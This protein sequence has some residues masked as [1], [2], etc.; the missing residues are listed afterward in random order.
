M[1]ELPEVVTVSRALK[2]KIDHLF[3][4]DIEIYYDKI[5]DNVTPSEFKEKLIGQQFLRFSTLGKYLIFELSDYT[6][7]VHLRMEGKFYYYNEEKKDKHIHLKFVLSNND[8]LYYHD[9]RKFG[10]MYVYDKS[11]QYTCLNGLGL[12]LFNPLM[13]VKYLKSHI[14]DKMVLKQFLLDQHII[15]GIGNIYA[16]EICFALQLHPETLMNTLS[17]SQLQALIDE[18]III[19]NEAIRCGGTTIRSYT[20]SYEIS[21]RFQLSLKAHARE[22]ENCY[23][24]GTPIKKI[25]VVGRGTY[26]CCSCQKINNLKVAITGTMGSGKSQVTKLIKDMGYNTISCDELVDDL[27]NQKTVLKDLEKILDIRFGNDKIT[28]KKMVENVI[29]KNNNLNKEVKDYLYPLLLEKINSINSFP[30]FVE[31]PLLFESKWENNF[32]LN[33]L[34]YANDDMIKERLLNKGYTLENI[35]QR[36]KNQ[37]PLDKKLK[38][39]DI[40]INN[41]GSLDLLKNKVQ[42]LINKI[43]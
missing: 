20:S 22:K 24:C 2:D 11:A 30:L 21:G 37:M 42:E 7:I 25:R 13:N 19:L 26:F 6:L 16:D 15:L 41:E 4:K 36:I 8:Y 5:I 27:Y 33:I 1:P 31:V 18:G 34:V 14:K 32:N 12:E 39:C 10:K 23:I 3:I 9:T 17:D 38:R 43:V 28:N 35:N 29:F 40:S